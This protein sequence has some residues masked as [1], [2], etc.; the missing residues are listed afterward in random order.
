MKAVKLIH[1]QVVKGANFDQNS[2]NW[3]TRFDHNHLRITRIIRCLRVLGLEDE[4]LAFFKTLNETTTQTSD[5]S[6]EFWR[7]AA[8]RDLNIRPD[9]ETDDEEDNSVGVRFLR[10]YEKQ[11]KAD[12]CAK[13]TVASSAEEETGEAGSSEVNNASIAAD[14]EGAVASEVAPTIPG[15]E[16]STVPG[17]EKTL[18]T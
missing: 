8:E 3:D 10:E 5:R 7:R 12:A 18:A 9:L 11:R 15:T 2:Q 17:D 6:R 13:E 14:Q 4:A 16:A 1:Q